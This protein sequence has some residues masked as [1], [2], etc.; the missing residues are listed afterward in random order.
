MLIEVVICSAWLQTLASKLSEVVKRIITLLS[1][2]EKVT[3]VCNSDG[4]WF[5]HPESKRVWS[6]YTLC[7]AHTKE[8]RKVAHSS[9][10]CLTFC[11]LSE[12]ELWWITILS[13]P[14]GGARSLLHGHGGPQSVH[15]VPACLSHHLFLLQVSADVSTASMEVRP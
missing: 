8:R 13:L 4:Q 9:L 10:T 1:S 5:H 6:N 3:K 11:Q 12:G 14:A 15:R 2:T 7:P